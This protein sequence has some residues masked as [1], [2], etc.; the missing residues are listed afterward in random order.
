MSKPLIRFVP[1]GTGFFML[2][3]AAGKRQ[4]KQLAWDPA[5]V[6]GVRHVER[7]PMFKEGWKIWV[8]L[9]HVRQVTEIFMQQLGVT[10]DIV[11]CSPSK[12]D[13][14]KPMQLDEWAELSER[15]LNK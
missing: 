14:N 7:A 1:T 6:A 9:G 15:L 11:L 2:V 5:K 4:L 13:G 8:T 10:F 12:P 3:D